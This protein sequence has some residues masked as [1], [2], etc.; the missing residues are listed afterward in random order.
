EDRALERPWSGKLRLRLL[1]VGGR[2]RKEV[3]MGD[4]RVDE[5]SGVHDDQNDG[6]AETEVL[7]E[8]GGIGIAQHTA[9]RVVEERRQH[10]GDRDEYEQTRKK[11]GALTI[12]VLTL[13]AKA[14][15]DDGQPEA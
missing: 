4:E 9:L 12:E 2:T 15:G 14:A 8:R 3:A 7:V 13:A 1:A 11:P 5:I 10:H 6:N